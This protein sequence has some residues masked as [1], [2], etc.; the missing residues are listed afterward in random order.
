MARTS[1]I[2]SQAAAANEFAS[3]AVHFHRTLLGADLK[4][5]IVM[6]HRVDQGSPLA[7]V[8]G[9]RLLGIDVLARLAGVNAGDHA[10]KLARRHDH[11]VDILAVENLAVIL[12]D[13]PVSFVLRL[14]A[15]RTCDIAVAEGH[16]L[17]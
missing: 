6:P 15:F 1:R 14:E 4:H 8:Q 5:P 12:I 11:R 10:L 2:S 13:G 7:D 17:R 3:D 9:Q 16:D